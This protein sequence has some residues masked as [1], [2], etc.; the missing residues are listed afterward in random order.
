[1]PVSLQSKRTAPC[2]AAAVSALGPGDIDDPGITNFSDYVLSLPSVTAGGS[3]PGQN[4][5]G[6]RVSMNF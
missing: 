2:A 3:G 5:I 6:I 1:M 4:T